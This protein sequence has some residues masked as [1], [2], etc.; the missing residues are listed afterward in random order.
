MA[1][2]AKVVNETG[3]VP[4]EVWDEVIAKLQEKTVGKPDKE[5]LKAAIV[6]AVKKRIPKEPF[7]VFF[8]GGVDSALIA[9]ILKQLNADFTC[10]TV[11]FKHEESEIPWDVFYARK[12]AEKYDLKYVEKLYNV[13]EAK[14]VIKEAVMIFPAP[15]EFTT[16]YYV[17]IDVASVVVAAKKIAKE[18]IFFSGLGSEEI[19]AGYNRHLK[20][21]DVNEE[22]WRGLKEMWSRDL[23]RDVTLGGALGISL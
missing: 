3:L 18:K 20:T 23:Y 14:E 11:G 6:E 19:F 16:E 4:K 10:Y 9:L 7:G 17:T 15:K 5:K 8:S 13:N 21:E 22:C 2:L 12:L 1:K